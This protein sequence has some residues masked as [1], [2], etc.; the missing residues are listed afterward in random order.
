[1][2]EWY[3]HFVVFEIHCIVCLYKKPQE[4]NAWPRILIKHRPESIDIITVF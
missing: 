3:L 1:M 2:P 4:N